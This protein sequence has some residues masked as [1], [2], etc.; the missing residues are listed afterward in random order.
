LARL[1]LM[2]SYAV[3]LAHLFDGTT[4]A[5]LMGGVRKLWRDHLALNDA[6]L[7]LVTRTLGVTLR[8]NSGEELRVHLN[9]RLG[10]V[11]LIRVPPSEAGFFYDDLINKLHSQGRKDFDRGSFRAMCE[12]EHLFDKDRDRNPVTIGVRSFMHPIDDL[13]ARCDRALN[14]VPHF[15]GRFIRDEQAWNSTLFPALREFILAAARENDH[16]CLVL[17]THVSLAFG[18]G[19]ILNVKS[20]KDD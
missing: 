6:Q 20:W 17:D 10:R 8:L 4:D 11:G 1:I 19:A 16:L 13:G 15:D 5:S 3:D 2:Q 12:Q 7:R 18:I 14:L 9:D